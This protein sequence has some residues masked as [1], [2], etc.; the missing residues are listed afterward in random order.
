ME[1]VQ[2]WAVGWVQCRY[3]QTSSM[4]LIIQSLDRP[5]LR[6]CR[7]CRLC[8]CNLQIPSQPYLCI[9]TNTALRLR[10]QAT[11]THM[12]TDIY[13][14]THTYAHTHAHPRSSCHLSH[15]ADVTCL[16]FNAITFS[17]PVYLSDLLQNYRLFQATSI[18]R[19]Q[20]YICRGVGWGVEGSRLEAWMKSHK[21]EVAIT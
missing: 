4:D 21:L 14:Q 13:T 3:H 19:R 20:A 12:H 8:N 10:D 7:C 9:Y 1:T 2:R 17:G 6:E 5:S 16:C 11:H 18:F 15:P